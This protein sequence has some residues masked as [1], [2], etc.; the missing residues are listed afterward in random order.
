MLAIY[1]ENNINPLSGF[2]T[3]LIQLPIIFGLYWVFLKGGLTAIDTTILYSFIQ[4]PSEVIT[5]LF[6]VNMLEKS[7]VLALLAG[8]TQFVH[9]YIAMEPPV[10]N[11]KPGESMKDDIMRSLYIQTR[12]VLPV[13]IIVVA[14]TISAAIA[15]YWT[16]SN[17]FTIVQ[18]LLVRRKV[19]GT[20]KR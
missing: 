14:Y 1:K 16:A 18:E 13:V 9:A 17:L 6:G 3:L 8:G 10:T 20:Q 15:L 19:H 12:Y 4:A 11:T 7:L 2:L 5:H